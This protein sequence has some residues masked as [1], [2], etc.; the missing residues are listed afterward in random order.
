[1]KIE[2]LIEK[3][4]ELKE[5]LRKDAPAIDAVAMSE[6]AIKADK[7][8]QWYLDKVDPDHN[9]NIVHSKEKAKMA[10]GINGCQECHKTPC[11]CAKKG[12]I[13]G[14][15]EVSNPNE[16]GRSEMG[17]MTRIGAM[18]RAKASA[19]ATLKEMKSL[20]KPKLV[21]DEA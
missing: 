4:N 1:M 8:G 11:E 14:V 7:N 12:E 17:L 19:K 9:V 6:E 2:Q 20:P 10:S 21:K 5:E 3:F 18:D 15:H 16:Q 13:K